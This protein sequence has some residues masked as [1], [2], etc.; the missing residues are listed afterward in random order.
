MGWVLPDSWNIRCGLG[1]GASL[2]HTRPKLDPNTTK[3]QKYPNYI[4]IYIYIY[5][6]LSLS[7]TNFQTLI[8]LIL[9]SRFSLLTQPRPPQ[10]SCLPSHF[11]WPMPILTLNDPLTHAHSH[12]LSRSPL[13]LPLFVSIMRCHAPNPKGS[14]A[15]EKHPKGTCRFF[16]FGKSNY[17]RSLFSFLFQRIRIYNHTKIFILQV[18]AL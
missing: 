11:H 5:I 10:G 16:L 12:S 13:S 9:N 6:S 14:K 17:R 7:L 15:W 3:L 8:N 4:Y 1:S 18:R 2:R